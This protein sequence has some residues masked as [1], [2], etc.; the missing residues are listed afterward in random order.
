MALGKG[1]KGV[2]VKETNQS[3]S[4][5]KTKPKVGVNA[6]FCMTFFQSLPSTSHASHGHSYAH[7]SVNS[8]NNHIDPEKKHFHL[9]YTI[10]C[11]YTPKYFHLITE[12]LLV[13]RK[14]KTV[15][16]T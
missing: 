6:I 2:E 3:F 14:F 16:N 8:I 5:L 7:F 15:K 1:L 13:C 4:L 9:K 12:T 11:S 10:C